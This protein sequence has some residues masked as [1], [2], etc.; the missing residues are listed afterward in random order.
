MLL[1]LFSIHNPKKLPNKNHKLNNH[2]SELC[3]I[4][5]DKMKMFHFIHTVDASIIHAILLD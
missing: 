4:G 3:L 1:L 2:I 5:I